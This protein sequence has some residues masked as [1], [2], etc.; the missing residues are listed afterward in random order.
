MKPGSET[1]DVNMAEYL[2][3]HGFRSPAKFLHIASL[4][5][6]VTAFSQ[7]WGIFV[8]ANFFKEKK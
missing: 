4:I 8:K 7:R 1:R 5:E 6:Y 3:T 2:C